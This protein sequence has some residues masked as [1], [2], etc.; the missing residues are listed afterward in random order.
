MSWICLTVGVT[1]IILAMIMALVH[2]HRRNN[3]G[4]SG[5]SRSAGN[6]RVAYSEQDHAMA[7]LAAG[8]SIELNMDAFDDPELAIAKPAPTSVDDLM[9][10]LKLDDDESDDSD[11]SQNQSNGGNNDMPALT[12]ASLLEVQRNESIQAAQNNR[13]RILGDSARELGMR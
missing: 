10:L 8:G 9:S 12:L 1:F 11:D 7:S 5:K 2:A 6:K 4:I 3:P 13:P